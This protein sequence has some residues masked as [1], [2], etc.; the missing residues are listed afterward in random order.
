MANTVIFQGATGGPVVKKRR[1]ACLKNERWMFRKFWE[2]V[3]G[4]LMNQQGKNRSFIKKKVA[5]YCLDGF[6][7]IPGGRIKKGEEG[8]KDILSA[9]SVFILKCHYS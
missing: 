8:E 7:D 3:V 1:N 6:L 4:A 5:K 9:S 2:V